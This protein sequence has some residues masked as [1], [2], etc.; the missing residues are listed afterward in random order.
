MQRHEAVPVPNV[1]GKMA[2]CLGSKSEESKL[3]VKRI[4]DICS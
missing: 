1:L 3:E 4:G 2:P